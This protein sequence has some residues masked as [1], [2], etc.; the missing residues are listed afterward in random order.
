M[1]RLLLFPACAVLAIL[2]VALLTVPADAQHCATPTSGRIVGTPFVSASRVVGSGHVGRVGVGVGTS[3]TGVTTSHHAGYD[4]HDHH[5]E[6]VAVPV[7]IPAAVFQFLPAVT[8]APVVAVAAAE[9]TAV[10][11]QAVIVSTHHQAVAVTTGLPVAV[12][13]QQPQAVAVQANAV[14]TAAVGSGAAVGANHHAAS[15]AVDALLRDRLDA[16]LLERL[17]GSHKIGAAAPADPNALPVARDGGL[18][19]AAGTPPATAG[20]PATA[21]GG[22]A[23]AGVVSTAD[24]AAVLKNRCAS[25]HTGSRSKGDFPMFDDAGNLMNL[26]RSKRS[27]AFTV[28]ES[29]Q[30]PPSARGDAKA[31]TAVPDA[32]LQLLRSWAA[33]R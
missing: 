6:I 5:K 16:I 7:A 30:M 23:G 19:L 9:S 13:V 20:V 22:A 25:C 2:S 31:P 3:Y 4:H 11:T 14:G 27:L 21:S 12:A 15:A 1:N 24:V 18:P 32:E 29:A 10:A 26:E 8:Q 28:S 33:S 17:G